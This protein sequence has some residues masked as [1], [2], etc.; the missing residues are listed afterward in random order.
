[1]LPP[2]AMPAQGWALGAL[3][4]RNMSKGALAVA[5][6]GIAKRKLMFVEAGVVNCAKGMLLGSDWRLDRVA[7]DPRSAAP[8]KSSSG[9]CSEVY[10]VWL[11]CVIVDLI[12]K[13]AYKLGLACLRCV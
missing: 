13:V 4:F 1:M 7:A 8:L 9:S 3:T 12:V 10:I 2:H 11:S 6:E 5:V